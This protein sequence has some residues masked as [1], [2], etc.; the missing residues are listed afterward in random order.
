[1]RNPNTKVLKIY[2]FI[3]IKQLK[4]IVMYVISFR[5]TIL[6]KFSNLTR[7]YGNK[8]CKEREKEIIAWQKS[9]RVRLIS[10]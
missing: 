4:A 6:I 10:K 3:I 5:S 1:M 7:Y 9:A 8:N 2:N